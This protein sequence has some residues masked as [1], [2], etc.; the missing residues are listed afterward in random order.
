MEEYSQAWYD[1]E[2]LMEME[3]LESIFMDDFEF[4]KRSQ[5]Y[6]YEITLT[7]NDDGQS[8]NHV[9]IVLQ[10][11]IPLKY[12]H[13]PPTLGI[14]LKQGLNDRQHAE[15]MELLQEK[16][17]ENH[18]EPMIFTLCEEL[19]EYLF[20][21][22][23]AGN[24]GSE[25]QEMLFRAQV[26]QKKEDKELAVAEEAAH[27]ADEDDKPR[28]VEGTPVTAKTFAVWKEQF[29]A[30]GLVIHT[31]VT[32]VKPNLFGVDGKPKFSGR[33]LWIQG[34]AANT[35]EADDDEVE[36]DEEDNEDDD[37]SVDDEE[38]QSNVFRTAQSMAKAKIS[39]K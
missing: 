5:K 19:K 29:D 9:S 32:A 22:N 2:Q 28:N 26:Q 14:V 21:N 20:E 18:G 33:Q 30:E 37:S 1:E 24:D 12:P 7:P 4:V 11:D 31:V 39:A 17:V 15:M 35:N 34:L 10:V 6:A 8:I 16:V 25:Y 38:D 3:A 36:E 23:R 27:L 13:Q